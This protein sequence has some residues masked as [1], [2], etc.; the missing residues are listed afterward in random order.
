MGRMARTILCLSLIITLTLGASPAR[1]W[2]IFGGGQATPTPE[3]TQA[4]IPE[5]TLAASAPAGEEDASIALGEE[6]AGEEEQGEQGETAEAAE[7]TPL[8]APTPQAMQTQEEALVRVYLKSLGQV[9]GL[10]LT[11]VGSYSVENDKGFRFDDG[12]QIALAV[13]GEDLLMKVGGLTINMG[14]S[15]TLTRHA[16]GEG[17][18]CGAVIQET[19]RE[20]LYCGDLSLQ[21]SQGNIQVIVT[22]DVEDYLY[23][24][25]PYEMSDS[26]PLEALKAQ[27]VAARTFVMSRKN[28]NRAYDVVDT[29]NDQVYRGLDGST[30]N[31]ILAVDQTRGVVGWYKDG[32]AV[33]NFTATNGG[34]T[35]L[36]QHIWG[37]DGDYGYLAVVDDPYDLENPASTMKTLVLN[38][39]PEQWDEHLIQVLKSGLTEQMSALGY[40]DEVED[41]RILSIL[42]MEPVDPKYG[43]GNRMYQSLRVGMQVEGKKLYAAEPTPNA[44]TTPMNQ[45]EI[46]EQTLYADIDFYGDLKPNYGL[47]L[48]SI[49]CEILSVV[50]L[51]GEEEAGEGE[52]PDAYRLEVRRYGHGVGLSQRGAQWMAGTYGMTWTQ[53]LAFYYPGM[54]L[55]QMDY[56]REELVA[57]PDLPQSLGYAR[58]RPTPKPT[59]APLPALQEGE[60]YAAAQLASSDSTLNVRAEPSTQA[61]IVGTLDHG[62]RLIVVA[63]AGEG[64]AKIKTAELEGYCST[65]YI[66][67]EEP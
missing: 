44:M 2:W 51:A 11:L 45:A 6:T 29:A 42:S 66:K 59:P 21:V 25:V 58:A 13:E 8:P 54:T 22:L 33:C 55:V 61:P 52:T 64:W 27:A 39:D 41:I 20:N 34:Q 7:A 57:L 1:A 65:D 67:M 30:L 36:P 14:P 31:A 48:N 18:D 60:Q 15:M 56:A 49:D 24:V 63:Q 32:Y 62:Q 37:G 19:G 38:A 43:E 47:K 26:F 9:Q 50:P 10:N 5:P 23:G 46:L 40:S 35:E 3:P 4:A 17:E 12:T 53:I 28:A 16:V